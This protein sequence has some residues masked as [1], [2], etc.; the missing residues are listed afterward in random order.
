MP[1][2]HTLALACPR[3]DLRPG[4]PVGCGVLLEAGR[5]S[6]LGAGGRASVPSRLQDCIC[7]CWIRSLDGALPLG[8][9]TLISCG[10]GVGR[11]RSGGLSS[12]PSLMLLFGTTERQSFCL[13]LLPHPWGGRK[14]SIGE[15][16]QAEAGKGGREGNEMGG[17]ATQ[18]E[19]WSAGDPAGYCV[20]L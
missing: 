2:P 5:E 16:V 1:A 8:Q 10:G 19:A 18:Q 11:I 20:S 6:G 4:P 13:R 12:G 7:V 14:E 17:G 3:P 9:E 15:E